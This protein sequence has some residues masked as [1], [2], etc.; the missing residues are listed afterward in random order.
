[1]RPRTG[2][3]RKTADTLHPTRPHVGANGAANYVRRSV[4]LM[5]GPRRTAPK[6][7]AVGHGYFTA[8]VKRQVDPKSALK[9]LKE[10]ARLRVHR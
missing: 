1:M 10:V 2:H 9:S 6:S 5:F 7:G 8:T 3:A 4:A